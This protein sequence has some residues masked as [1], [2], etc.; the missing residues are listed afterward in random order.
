MT[1]FWHWLTSHKPSSIG[2]IFCDCEYGSIQF[3]YL[4]GRRK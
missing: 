4:K 2:A 3:N 1:R